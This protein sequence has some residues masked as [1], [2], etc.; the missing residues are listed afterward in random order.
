M[1]D[2]AIA[3]EMA[4]STVAE[5]VAP[6]V[7]RGLVVIEA[8]GSSRRGR[9]AA[10]LRFNPGA[11][12]VLVAQLGMTGARVAVTDLGGAMLARSGLDFSIAAGPKAVLEQV[13]DAFRGLLDEVQEPSN[14]VMGVGIALP[15]MVELSTAGRSS[16]APDSW[17]DYPIE[18]H[19]LSQ[20][21]TRSLVDHDVYLMALAEH[22]YRWPDSRVLLCL[23]VG[24]VIGCGVVVDGNIVRGAQ[25]MSGEIGHS[26]VG[27]EEAPCWCGNIGCLDA[28][29]GG[30]VLARSLAAQGLDCTSA[31]DVA[32][33]AVSG[34]P[35]AA[36]AVRQAG[37]D[38]GSVLSGAVNL[39]NPD[40]VALWGY[41]ADAD[42][43]LVAGIRETIY[44]GSLPASTRRL[45]LVRA[46]LG[47]DA[48][49]TGAA[50][51]VTEEIFCEA[52]V[53]HLIS[54][55]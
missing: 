24:T 21:G 51:M 46:G 34:V 49:T 53:N 4:R 10:I 13:A 1:S 2:L 38:I 20:Y 32:R 15:S 45:E 26:R 42:D 47:D 29:A 25:G 55:C 28:V 50:I 31:K 17:E 40:V 35:E 30:G 37:R 41:L 44:Q 16:P 3:M 12:V 39:L 9:P 43:Q 33:L 36:Q 22:R 14:R 19:F 7:A 27:A 6:L 48:G 5:R 52:S 8:N 18:D 54:T 11:G 23:K